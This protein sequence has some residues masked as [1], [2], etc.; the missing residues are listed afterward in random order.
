MIKIEEVK[1]AG[2]EIVI[3]CDDVKH[4]IFEM[5]NLTCGFMEQLPKD[6]IPFFL[7]MLNQAIEE[8]LKTLDVCGIMHNIIQNTDIDLSKAFNEKFKSTEKE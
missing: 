4:A 5:I 3:N 6:H 2:L 8:P 7:G 1:N